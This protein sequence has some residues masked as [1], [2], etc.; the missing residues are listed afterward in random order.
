MKQIVLGLCLVGLVAQISLSSPLYAPAPPA[1]SAF[2]RLVS[3]LPQTTTLNWGGAVLSLKPNQVSPYRIFKQ[4]KHQLQTAQISQSIMLEAGFFYTAVLSA[5]GWWF[6]QDRSNASLIQARIAVY[7]TSSQS[8][9]V[10]TADG[11]QV[12]WDR[13]QPR[14]YAMQPVNPVKVRLAVGLGQKNLILPESQL[15]PN[16]AYSIFVFGNQKTNQA[17]WLENSTE[18][19]P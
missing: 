6:N 5:R 10:K 11:Q 12:L 7:N 3:T 19:R 4:G 17:I 13:V 16:K 1:N 15:E 18:V 9:Q 2:V 14:S 8:I